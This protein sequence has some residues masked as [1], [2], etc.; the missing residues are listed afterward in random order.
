MEE[1]VFYCSQGSPDDK[2]GAL[3]LAVA[4]TLHSQQQ[5]VAFRQAASYPNGAVITGTKPGD[6]VLV[7]AKGKALINVYSWGKESPDQRIPVPEQLACLALCPNG[8]ESYS[9]IVE[10]ET[11]E[12]RL[13][14]FRLPYLLIGGGDSKLY[15]VSKDS[16]I[17]VYA[18]QNFTLLSTF[19]INGQIQSI[20]VDSADRAMYV[21]LADGHIRIINLYEA[22]PATNVLE[23][24]G[25]HGKVLTL[26]PDHELKETITYHAGHGVTQLALSLDGSLVISGDEKGR[27]AVIDVVS[28]QVVKELKELS[29]SITSVQVLNT[30][31]DVSVAGQQAEKNT[32]VIPTFKRV[33]TTNEPKEQDV[34]YQIADEQEEKLF[35]IDA[36]LEKVATEAMFFENFTNVNSEVVMRDNSHA[37][38]AKL[39]EA[40]DKLDKVTKAYSDLRAMYE[41]LYSEHAALLEKQ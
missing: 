2:Q 8:T 4:T 6:R 30:F 15:T 40:Q 25:G 19:V 5:T 1:V 34:L 33:I 23:A 11:N 10:D 7:A 31:N 39:K 27:V 16:T 9:D 36:H 28:K 17:R 14:K 18:L 13:P 3:S 21:G 12:T 41:Q 32:R 38:G 29:G 26:Q 20:T 37:D 35:D 24:R 22:N